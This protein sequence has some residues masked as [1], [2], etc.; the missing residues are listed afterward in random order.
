LNDIHVSRPVDYQL[1]MMMD[2]QGDQAPPKMKNV[3]KILEFIHEDHCQTIHELADPL[4]S[5]ME[6]ARRS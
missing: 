1:K 2:V 5:V 4:G 3:E 6:F